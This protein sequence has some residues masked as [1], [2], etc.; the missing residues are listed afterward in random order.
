MAKNLQHSDFLC[1]FA[2]VFRNRLFFRFV[3]ATYMR[4]SDWRDRIER[5]SDRDYLKRNTEAKPI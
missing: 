3:C 2:L 5:E 1:I 4:K